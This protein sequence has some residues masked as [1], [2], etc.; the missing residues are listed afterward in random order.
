MSQSDAPAR[1][2]QGTFRLMNI[3]L[4]IRLKPFFI[5]LGW[6]TSTAA[7][8]LGT[9]FLGYLLP[10]NIN[11]GGLLSEVINASA[12]PIW[13]FYVG[14]FAICIL[15]ALVISDLSTSLISFFVSYLG[16]GIIT[17]VVLALP[18]LLGCCAGSLAES[19]IGFTLIAFFPFLFFVN[20]TGTLL[21]VWLNE[22]IL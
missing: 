12:I 2:V 7:L 5:M 13:I 6:A 1:R 4:P 3:R 21:G 11:G 18:D 22:Y 10:K 17:Y 14:N 16:A 20:L 8:T 15:A 9:I 19:A